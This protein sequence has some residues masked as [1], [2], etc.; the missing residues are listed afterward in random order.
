MKYN[1]VQKIADFGRG[2]LSVVYP[3]KCIF[4]GEIIEET[5]DVC[6]VCH[7]ELE[8]IDPLKRCIKCGLVKKYCQC[9]SRVFRFEGLVSVF[10]YTGLAKKGYFKYKFSGREQYAGYFAKCM[11]LAV[12]NEYGDI[13]FD[14]LCGVPTSLRSKTKRG[15]GH[16]EILCEHISYLTGIPY[17]DKIIFC[18]NF[19][20]PQHSH[21]FGERFENIKGKYYTKDK[22]NIKGATVL[23]VDDIKTTGASLD[24]CARVLLW[25]GADKVYCV[26][27]LETVF[28]NK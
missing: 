26:T 15:Y 27:L 4:C 13:K 6:T 25:A 8:R 22:T 19:K 17:A 12:K 16:T 7:R 11:A 5:E 2:M 20:K 18:K 9:S 14:F 1:I 21:G 28:K 23:L 10:E 3:K 24:E